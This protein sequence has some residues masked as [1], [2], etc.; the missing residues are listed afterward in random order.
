[1]PLVDAAGP[2]LPEGGPVHRPKDL[3]GDRGYDSEPHREQLRARG[4]VPHLAKRRTEHGSGLGVFRW[5]AERTNS[6]LHGFRKLRFV[7]EKNDEM[8][9]AFFNLGLALIAFRFLYPNSFC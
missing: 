5:V 1:M 2:Q 7:T 4:I 9:F 3:Y 8:Q 6:W